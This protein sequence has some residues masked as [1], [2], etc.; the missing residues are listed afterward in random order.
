MAPS[1]FADVSDF[2]DAGVDAMLSIKVM[3]QYK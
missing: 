1:D 3:S 2:E